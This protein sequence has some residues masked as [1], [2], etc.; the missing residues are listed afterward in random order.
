MNDGSAFPFVML[1]LGLLG[2]HELG[3]SGLRWVL[4]DVLWATAGGLL[5]GGIAGVA[6]AQGGRMLRGGADKH[7]LMDDFLG[8]GLIGVVYGL[9]SMLHAWGFLAVFFA[10]VALRQTELRLAGTARAAPQSLTLPESARTEPVIKA[11]LASPAPEILPTVSEGALIF[12]EHL[13]RLSELL[14]VLLVGGMLYLNSWSWEAVGFTL[15]LFVIARPLSVL[16]ALAGTGTAWRI[17][18]MTGWFGVRGIG[19]LYYL[20]YAIQHGLP[21]PLGLKLIQL[22]L[23]VITMSIL[24]HGVS[25]KPLMEHVWQ[26]GKRAR[27]K[28]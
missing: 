8:L 10:A 18:A 11:P 15:F 22:T 12:K 26:R 6:L 25:V 19:S 3:D 28:E 27:Q 9:S 17:Q 20:M 5:I 24:L 13:E 16:I 23:I 2:L 4:V 21:E 7:Q 14:L 1:G